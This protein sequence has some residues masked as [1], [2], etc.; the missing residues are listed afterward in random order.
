MLELFHR[1]GPVMY[2]LALCSVAALAVFLERLWSLRKSRSLPAGFGARFTEALSHGNLDTALS[3]CAEYSPYP[4]ARIAKAGLVQAGESPEMIRFMVT[5]VGGQEAAGLERYQRI[6]ATVAYIAPLLGLLGTVSGMIKAFDSIS[7]HSLGD[8][9][10]LAGG[11]S[12]ALITTAAGLVVAIPVVIMH[13]VVQSRASR[14]SLELEKESV[15]LTEHL[16][17]YSQAAEGTVA[18]VRGGLGRTDPASM[19]ENRLAT[20]TLRKSRQAG[21]GP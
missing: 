4:V 2:P 7:H 9:A 13:K 6:I 14:I 20:S 18:K 1:G 15:A 12:E 3:L 19:P 8:P 11:I 17:K 21:A 10:L 16:I 5:E